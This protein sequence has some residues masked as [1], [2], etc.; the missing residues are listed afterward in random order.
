MN[1]TRSTL[2][3]VSGLGFA[4]SA[5]AL[6]V[7]VVG[8]RSSP[9]ESVVGHFVLFANALVVFTIGYRRSWYHAVRVLGMLG[10]VCTAIWW[11][12]GSRPVVGAPI[13]AIG[14]L[15]TQD[16]MKAHHS[17]VTRPEALAEREPVDKK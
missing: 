11:F 13:L 2:I 4:A 3:L 16:A 15:W 14:A 8:A 10:L 12:S 6:I 5:L 17:P 7:S 9:P 1:S